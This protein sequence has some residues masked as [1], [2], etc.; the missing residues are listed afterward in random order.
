[1]ADMSSNAK[2]NDDT[3]ASRGVSMGD[4]LKRNRS[5]NLRVDD[6][7]RP[8]KQAR[9]IDTSEQGPVIN[10]GEYTVGWVCALPLEMAAAKGMLDQIHPD[11]PQDQADHNNYILGQIQGHNIVIACLP[12]GIYGTTTAAT[13]AKDLLRTFKSIRFGLLVGIGGGAPSR[14]NDIRLGDVVVSQPTGTSG[15]VIQ[16]DR[17]KT[18]QHGE[19]QRT[20]SL[21]SPPQVLLTAL[22]RL[23]TEHMTNGSKIPQY[24]SELVQKSPERV[25]RRFSYQGSL[26]DHLFQAKYN[27]VSQ[28]S[29]C[30]QCDPAHTIQRDARDDTEPFIHYG[31][32]ASGNQVIKHGETRDRLARGLGA[33]CFEMEAAGLQDFPC[34]VIRGICDYSDSHKNKVW[35]EYA[36]ATAAAFAKEL[37]SIIRP[38]KVLEEK[39]IQQLVSLTQEHLQVS[40]DHYNIS[41]RQL[42][43]HKRTNEI[44]E[45][46]CLDLPIVYEAR[47][48]S[49]DVQDSPKCAGGTRIRFQETIYRWADDDS[50]EPFFWLVGPAGTGKS[51]IARTIADSLAKKKRLAAGYFFKRGE[52]GRNDT[53]RLIPT[54]AIQ[55]ADTVPYFKG[56]LRSCLDG[57]DRDAIEK[58][59]L[60]VQFDKLILS[61]LVELASTNTSQEPWV[62]IIDALD[63]CERPEHLPLVITLLGRLRHV[64]TIRFR[65]LFTSR[66][67][68][69][70]SKA[71]ESFV[72]QK[73]ACKLQLHRVFFEDSMS[74][75]QTFLKIRF[76]EIKAKRGVQQ[77]PWPTFEDLDR[78]V[79]LA[80]TP[81]PLF[82]YAATLC[83]F[84]YDEKRPRNP[85]SQLKLWLKQCNLGRSQLCQI[86]DPILSQVLL[87]NEEAE[88]GQQLQFLAAL[89][90]LATP[91]PATC[92]ANLLGIDIDDVNWWL[93]ELHAVLDIPPE[94]H[95]PV[96]LLHKSFSD[97]ILSL[98]D[99]G[100]NKYRIDATETHNL[101]A[102]QCIQR[103]ETG[104][105]RDI[106]NIQ[107]PDALKDRIDKQVLDLCIPADLRYAC[108]YWVY[109]LQNSGQHL[110]DEMCEFLYTHFLHWLEVLALLGKVSD[111]A[112]ALR[113]LLNLCQGSDAHA[114]L[115]DFIKD[116]SKIVASFGSI[117]EQAP[118]QIYQALMLFSPLESRVRN[119]FSEQCL[120]GLPRVYDVKP[121]WDAHRLTLEGHEGAVNAVAF[122]SDGQLVAS[123]SSD[124]TVRLWDAATGAH[125]QTFEGHEDVV[126]SVV[127]LPD[128]Q[129]VASGSKYG[130]VQLWDIATGTHK[131]TLG[132]HKS[133][134]SARTFSPDS[135]VVALVLYV[136]IELWDV[137]TGTHY[138]T[139]YAHE[140]LI[141]AIAFSPDSQV[142]AAAL[143]N[144]T[145]QLWDVA[146]GKHYQTLKGEESLIHAIAFSPDNQVV[147]AALSNATVWLWDVATGVQQQ[148]FEGYEGSDYAVAF[149]PD[150]QVLSLA[151][152]NGRI[153]LWDVATGTRYQP[154]EGH[155]G[156]IRAIA[157]SPDSQTVASASDDGTV[158]LWNVASG[159]RQQEFKGYKDD[160]CSVV[161][162][163][164]NQTVASAS[165]DGTLRLFH[166]ATGAHQQTLESH[167]GLINLVAFSPDSQVIAATLSNSIIQLWDVATGVQQ[168]TLEGHE[169]HECLV[170]AIVFSPDSQILAA[171]FFDGTVQFWDVA[172]GAHQETFEGHKQCVE[173]VGFSPD[174]Q[175]V[176]SASS[177]R[178]VRL[179]DVA[180]GK[181]L[182]TLE[183]H[184]ETVITVVFS[185]NSKIVASASLD[186]TVR[187]WD[188]ATGAH[189]QT[190]KGH[191]GRVNAIAFS[192]DD[193]LVVSASDDGTVRL[194]DA[195]TGA[196]RHTLDR[197]FTENL[198][199]DP[200]SNTRLFT[201]FGSVDLVASS[202]VGE[203]CSSG[204]W[205]LSPTTCGLGL[206]PD[207]TWIMEG[208]E[209]IVWLPIEYRPVALATKGSAMFIGCVS[210]RVIRIMTTRA[211]A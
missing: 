103:M 155:K 38:E 30:D 26:N 54:L 154:L 147:A 31:T 33:L 143:S 158:W 24:L 174:G 36:A 136:W 182:Q 50:G 56:H 53:S 10:S 84:V 52:K 20:G 148:K 46:R 35:Q 80:T 37:L 129:V 153:Q 71:L 96:R 102:A 21:N 140:G 76:A 116:A 118:L 133:R 55:L 184:E 11:I 57:L 169:G 67:T 86:Y 141:Y 206:S 72:T 108:L 134:V 61:P 106:C 125:Q 105:R 205:R 172:T 171:A 188:V 68:P 203:P 209:K 173:A 183:G 95:Q 104:L 51:T 167:S 180:T 160:I 132:D 94:P 192:P 70:V 93:P 82:I 42:S 123:A 69:K 137:A 100:K 74:D 161:C 193:Q 175:V 168:Q 186:F 210:G 62:I 23:Q 146:T 9:T 75:I 73:T 28:D 156:L 114:E 176:A 60:G 117:I 163:P 128:G 120:P 110:G 6:P 197:C 32:I 187:L 126:N 77:D 204:V 99:A 159:A 18:V 165:N 90:L 13:V 194:W 49:L 25:K 41:S 185:L 7:V 208:K 139:I 43:E 19:F 124:K 135:H 87:G 170:T 8:P 58:K 3:R 179:W 17:G 115:I 202:R 29:S 40:T 195:A 150:G 89:V 142:V 44:L 211:G 5:T 157:F 113:Q 101:L 164:D 15:G 64:D 198:I 121:N 181:H 27:H 145:I 144:G 191:K 162:S 16:Y 85:K 109:H 48:D 78:V 79:Q 59:G 12:A 151:S 149:S 83:R 166:T 107:K 112:G 88:S 127:F 119:R 22:A 4:G 1:M 177:D 91:L 47:Y 201:D 207:H 131:Q 196:H 65:V 39:P 97:F 190:L 152:G 2:P 14:T 122:S 45:S 138:R 199:F 130:K 66:P 200:C 34:L 178:T 92:L 63:E 81:E 189:Q 98:E 111:G